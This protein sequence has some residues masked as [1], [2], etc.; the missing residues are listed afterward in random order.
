MASPSNISVLFVCLGN[1]CRSPTAHGV[2]EQMVRDAGLAGQIEV[3]SAGTGDWHVGRAPDQRA[4]QAVLGRGVDISQLR[5]RQ[6]SA[7]DFSRYDY[8]LAMDRANLAELEQMRP[9]WFQGYLGLFLPFAGDASGYVD[10]VPDPYHGGF[11][12]FEA[13]YQLVYGASLGLLGHL[14]QQLDDG[15]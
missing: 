9:H 13:V 10:E 7:A 15:A 2:F 3:D 11:D 14:R 8:V 6:V 5:A 4:R 12:D 1:I